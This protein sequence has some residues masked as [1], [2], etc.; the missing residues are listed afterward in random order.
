MDALNLEATKRHE[1]VITGAGNEVN[2]IT[3]LFFGN[4][5][6]P[7]SRTMWESGVFRSGGE[8]SSSLTE[9]GGGIY[10]SVPAQ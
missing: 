7:D 4:S 9:H 3:E 2:S 8:G 6:G 5:K 10:R 1:R